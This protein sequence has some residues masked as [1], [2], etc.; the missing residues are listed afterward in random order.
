M[1]IFFLILAI[2]S[3][4][5]GLLVSFTSYLS[6]GVGLFGT[7]VGSVMYI[8]AMLSVG[9]GTVC[10]V[11]GC[12]KLSKGNTKQA[13]ALVLASV[14]YSGLLLAGMHMW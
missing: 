13:V 2:L 7:S 1:K 9:I 8:A 6:Q 3:I 12:I 14:A 10:T 4:P 5:L 11:L